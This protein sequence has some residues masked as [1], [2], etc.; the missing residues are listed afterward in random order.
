MTIINALKKNTPES[1]KKIIRPI[2]NLF[3]E[4]YSSE[5]SFWKGRFEVD[6]GQFMNSYYERIFLAMAQETTG[7]FLE[8]KVIADFGCGPRGSLAWVTS[9]SLKIGIDVLT[10]QYADE[11]KDNITSHGMIYLKS[12]ERV[13]PLP[14]NFVDIMFTL[15][16]MDH[17]NNFSIMCHEILRVMK[18]GAEFIGSFNMEENATLCEPQKLNEK[19]IEEHLLSKLEV[20]SYR[21]T[22]KGPKTDPHAFLQYAP[23]FN[24]NLSY[25]PGKE[26]FLWVR[27][28]KPKI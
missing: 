9:A 1:V 26:G 6:N 11:F 15:N 2:R 3:R 23:F 17:T 5:L 8:K 19:M 21:I 4:K 22:E 20:Q 18:P 10:D 27:A 7:E 16:A 25:R 13:I 14:P 28:R 24:N 12:T